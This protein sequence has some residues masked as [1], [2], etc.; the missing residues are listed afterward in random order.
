MLA[1][2]YKTYTELNL[3]SDT[4]AALIEVQERLESRSIRP[5]TPDSLFEAGDYFSFHQSNVMTNSRG[6]R[7]GCIGAWT[8]HI[9]GR[10]I[11]R[12]SGMDPLLYRLFYEWPDRAT[13]D[14]QWAAQRIDKFR[15]GEKL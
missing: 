7:L 14:T 2:T 1:R 13:N 15:R 3:K 10:N 6:C 4:L 8:S 11:M 5:C 12:P 9:L